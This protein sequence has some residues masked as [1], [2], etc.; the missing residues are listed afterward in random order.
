[1]RSEPYNFKY[2]KLKYFQSSY[3][4]N[5]RKS[6]GFVVTIGVIRSPSSIP[7]LANAF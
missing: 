3:Y 7:N 1:M 2:I 6:F 4:K 5:L